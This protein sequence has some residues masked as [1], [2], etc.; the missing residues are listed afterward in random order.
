[1]DTLNTV[2]KKS[3]EPLPEIDSED[4]AALF[5]RFGQARVV[6]IGEASHGSHEFY[7]ARAAITRHLVTDHGFTIVAVEADWPDADKSI[8]AS[9]A[10]TRATGTKRPS[11]ASP[12]GCGATP[13]SSA[14]PAG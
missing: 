3:A 11:P 12:P 1:M 4:F 14:S 2:L 7:Q 5:D 9:E 6:L 13:R 10:A 8:A